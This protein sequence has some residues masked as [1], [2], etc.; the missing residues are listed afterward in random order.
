M[1]GYWRNDTETARAFRN[2]LFRTGDV[3]YQDSD[4]YV[5]IL[6]RAK[7]M[8]VTG[9]EKVFSAEVEAVIAEL[10]AVREVAVFGTPDPQWGERVT[11]YVVLVPGKSLTAE[12]LTAHCRRSLAGF[13]CPRRVEFSAT[14]LPKDGAGKILKTVLRERAWANQPRNVA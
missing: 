10:P 8:I 5:F 6:D 9:G 7:D 2:G 3:G 13:Q 4:G 1:A 14:E 11:A 12:E